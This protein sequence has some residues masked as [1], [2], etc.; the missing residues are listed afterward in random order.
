MDV[1]DFA[2]WFP[3][4]IYRAES[5]LRVQWFRR[6]HGLR[7]EDRYFHET[8]ARAA[9]RPFN[10]AF[11]RD[12]PV[13]TLHSVAASSDALP[14][15]GLIYHLSR[16]GSTLV[17]SAFGARS[18]VLMLA[19]PGPVN[20]ALTI[21]DVDD[22]GRIEL[23]RDLVRVLSRPQRAEQRAC[24][25]KLDAWHVRFIP[26]LEAAFSQV[27]WIFIHRDPR[28]VLVS[29]LR[30][31]SFM[32]SAVNAPAATGMALIE[33]VRV[34]RE[35]YCA[36]VISTLLDAVRAR[37]PEAKHL[38]AYG[39]LPDAI[40]TRIGPAFG[41]PFDARGIERVKR[42]AM[43]HAKEPTRPF[44]PDGAEKMEAALALPEPL[45]ARLTERYSWFEVP[46]TR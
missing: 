9:K 45:L 26:L 15:H 46:S 12:T 27:P 5:G 18:D 31:T 39:E 22:R 33:A 13:D 3:V 34:P 16:C 43:M 28:E 30:L 36:S 23:V 38:V 32:M 24:V 20:D 11:Y 4:R 19:E 17:S 8:V 2:W 37:A 29:H 7:F 14:L 21:A 6:D 10:L 35:E 25:I 40:W 41:L 42:D 44:A 1:I